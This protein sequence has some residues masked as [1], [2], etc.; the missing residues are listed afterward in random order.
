LFSKDYYEPVRHDLIS[1]IPNDAR[2][3][4]SIGCGWGATEAHVAQT[5]R[6]VVVVALDSVMA[7]WAERRG[8]EVISGDLAT[9]RGKLNG[10][11]FDCLL[12]SNILHLA[13][14]PAHLLSLFAEVLSNDSV[15][16]AAVPNLPLTKIAWKRL[17]GGK[18]LRALGSFRKSGVHV[19]S[20][21]V[22][23]RWFS[24]AGLKVER[25]FYHV[26]GRLEVVVRRTLGL[27]RPIVAWEIAVIGIPDAKKR[28]NVDVSSR[29]SVIFSSSQVHR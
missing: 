15:V 21:R 17:H 16:I 29:E 6:R 18:R 26:P 11:S 23:R 24:E 2:N 12:I 4:L 27:L 28:R 25:L 9:T 3:V 13:D 19:T 10:E 22:V 8:L 14:D 1:L 20:D 7:L 5:G